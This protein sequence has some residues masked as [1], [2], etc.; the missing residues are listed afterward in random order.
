MLDAKL[1]RQ[2]DGGPGRSTRRASLHWATWRR[3]GEAAGVAGA[4]RGILQKL[5]IL[6]MLEGLRWLTV[7]MQP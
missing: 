6:G 4:T 1:G 3:L 5:C 7:K 2:I